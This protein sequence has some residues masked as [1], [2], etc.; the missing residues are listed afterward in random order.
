MTTAKPLS[1]PAGV[2]IRLERILLNSNCR[3]RSTGP[4]AIISDAVG[5]PC[6]SPA[7]QT[8]AASLHQPLPLDRVPLFSL[9]HTAQDVSNHEVRPGRSAVGQ[10]TEKLGAKFAVMLYFGRK[11][12]ERGNIAQR[13]LLSGIGRHEQVAIG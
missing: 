6:L 3:L 8:R 11:L 12:G 13:H 4:S 10:G 7:N 1:R 9:N 5:I 2:F